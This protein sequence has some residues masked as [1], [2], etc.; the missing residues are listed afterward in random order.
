MINQVL[1]RIFTVLIFGFLPFGLLI[2]VFESIKNEKIEAAIAFLCLGWVIYL[3]AWSK[4]AFALYDAEQIKLYEAW[5]KSRVFLNTDIMTKLAFLP[6]IGFLFDN[7]I[8]RNNPSHGDDREIKPT[9][10]EK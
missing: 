3:N 1:Q 9:P 4:K 7:W 6:G 8:N 5:S 10:E 2:S